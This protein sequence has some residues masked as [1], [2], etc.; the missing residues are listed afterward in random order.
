MKKVILSS[1][2]MVALTTSFV[3][4]KDAADKAKEATEATAEAANEA[5]DAT[6][7]A[8]GEAMDATKEAAGDAMDAAGELTDGVPSFGDAAVTEYVKTYEEYINEYKEAAESKDMT[9]FAALGT[10][11]QELATKSQEVYKNLS[12]A[13]A[14]KLNAYMTEKSKELQDISAKMMAN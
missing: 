6:K 14:E 12:A 8:A 7:E 3:S 9:A 4:C 13:D 11:G 1:I 10:K 2:L 5:A